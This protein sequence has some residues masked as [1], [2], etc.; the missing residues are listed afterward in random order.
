M[1]ESNVVQLAPNALRR[2]LVNTALTMPEFRSA[3]DEA[4]AEIRLAAQPMVNEATIESHFERVV[5]ALLRDIGLKFNPEKEVLAARR[6]TLQGRADSRLG[7]LVIEYKRPALLQTQASQALAIQQLSEYLASFSKRSKSPHE[8]ILTNGLVVIEIRAIDGVVSAP[9]PAQPL[10]GL[11][12]RRLTQS[13]IS[14]ALSA[15]TAENLIRD[16]CGSEADGILFHVARLLDA[17]LASTPEPKTRMLQ[18]EWEQLFRVSHKDVSKQPRIDARRRALSEIFEHSIKSPEVEYRSLFALHTA[19]AILLKFIAYRVVS[20]VYLGRVSQDFQALVH[21][22]PNALRIFCAE[23]E[24]GAIFRQLGILNLLEGDFFS[25]YSDNSQ[26]T[27]G[28]AEAVQLIV[29]ILARYEEARNVFDSNEAEDLFRELYQAAV[30]RTIRSSFGEVYTPRWLAEYVLESAQPNGQW[31]ALDPCCGSGT[32]VISAIS[33]LRRESDSTGP[34]LRKRILSRVVAIDL[35]PLAVLTARVHYFIHISD[36]LEEGHEEFVIPVYLGDAASRPI[37]EKIDGVQCLR[38][39]LQTLRTPIDCVL[40]ASL[41]KD[42]Q[43]F[44]KLMRRYEEFVQDQDAIEANRL[45]L[46]AVPE[47]DKKRGVRDA[48]LRLTREL[49]ALEVQDWNGIWARI[50]SNFLTTACLGKFDIIIGNPPWIDW[51]N[52][53]EGYRERIKSL[54]IDRGLFSGAGRTGGINLNICALIAHVSMTNWL[55]KQDAINNA[56]GIRV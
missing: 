17:I 30:P 46:G 1:V 16:F 24:D 23:L 38:Y 49:I 43:S 20:D 5:Y 10:N 26:W 2:K 28:L 25:W 34:A 12:L 56:A 13:V 51:K 39:Q 22:P 48:V 41:V 40:P 31:R 50:L 33:R 45:L 14:L 35:H 37:R 52:L 54:C 15:L 18:S 8:G 19:Y 6:H 9:T 11:A 29:S 21:A 55:A 32:F 7:A 3:L 42:P 27:D 44:I 53:P 36:L 4:A 47:S